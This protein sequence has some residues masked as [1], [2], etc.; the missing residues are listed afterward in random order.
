MPSLARPLRAP[1]S[2][3]GRL[4]AALLLAAALAG[5]T[6]TPAEYAATLSPQDPK[7][8]T[9]QCQQVRAEAAAYRQRQLNWAAGA[10]IGPYGLAIVA[11]GKD[12]QEKQRKL[13]ARDMHLACSSQPLPKDLRID[14]SIK[15]AKLP[16]A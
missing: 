10:L 8:A 7:F 15:R 2:R 3:T 4:P 13:F 16:P 12:F 14:P 11:A 5:C 6:S 9:P 1:P